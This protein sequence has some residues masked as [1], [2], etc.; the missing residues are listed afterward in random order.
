MEN[1]QWLIYNINRD[2]IN[3]PVGLNRSLTVAFY[4]VSAVNLIEIC[5]RTN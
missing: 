1:I 5:S 2:V 3:V 4:N